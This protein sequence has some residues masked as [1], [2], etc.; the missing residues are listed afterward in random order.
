MENVENDKQKPKSPKVSARIGKFVIIGGVV[1]VLNFC[2]Y[3]FLANVIIKN[4]DFL[5]LSN[6]IATTIATIVAYF[7][8]SSITWK[9]RLI[10]K[11]AKYK[12]IVWNLVSALI[13][14]PILTQLFSLITPLYDLA[15]NILQGMNMSYEFVQ[16]TGAFVLTTIITMVINYLFY[17]K[18]VFGKE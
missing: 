16:S 14:V 11:T 4:V 15:F 6:L 10:T 13:I 7:L 17:D 2:I 1:T 8:H 18:F 9:E 3:A 12:F 5:W